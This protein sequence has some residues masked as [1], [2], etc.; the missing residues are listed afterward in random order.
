[1]KESLRRRKTVT[2]SFIQWN[3]H[4]SAWKLGGCK[5]GALLLPP[6]PQDLDRYLK[7]T[8]KFFPP[9]RIFAIDN[10]FKGS[11]KW[12]IRN[13]GRGWQTFGIVLGPWR[14]MSVYLLTLPSSFL[15]RFS[16]SAMYRHIIRRLACHVNRRGTP[17]SII[18]SLIPNGKGNT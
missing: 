18:L 6:L 10:T 16:V 4:G 15:Q 3:I 14:W 9:L 2:S 5:G 13:P 17:N 7:T 1:M 8:W 11:V 12:K